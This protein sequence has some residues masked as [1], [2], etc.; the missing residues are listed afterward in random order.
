MISNSEQSLIERYTRGSHRKNSSDLRVALRHSL[1]GGYFASFIIG[2][3]LAT[4]MLPFLKQGEVFTA[5]VAQF[6]LLPIFTWVAV[7]LS[8]SVLNKKYYVEDR[9][10]VINL[11]TLFLVL[12]YFLG[13]ILLAI[14]VSGK[15]A[16]AIDNLEDNVVLEIISYAGD[17]LWVIVFYIASRKYLGSDIV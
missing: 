9:K 17:I 10:R 1:I 12:L 11:S 5:V 15:L 4:I 8:A 14:L 3:I 16:D 2:I 6:I 13:S 7:A